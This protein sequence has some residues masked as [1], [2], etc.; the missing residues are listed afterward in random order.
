MAAKLTLLLSGTGTQKSRGS[1]PQKPSRNKS[2][3]VF[4]ATPRY[5]F[6]GVPAKTPATWA[7]TLLT[8]DLVK[9]NKGI[10]FI[11]RIRSCRNPFL[12][13]H[14]AK[15]KG[16]EDDTRRFGL[17]PYNV[18]AVWMLLTQQLESFG[19]PNK[20]MRSICRADKMCRSNGVGMECSGMT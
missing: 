6:V 3:T 2:R 12:S 15:R 10:P 16:F 9:T 18:P 13:E 5:F 17:F 4:A 1:C 11:G 14:Q 19:R 20:Q 8:F 7:L